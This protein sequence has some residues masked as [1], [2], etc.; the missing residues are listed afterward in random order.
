MRFCWIPA[1]WAL[2]LI[3]R[4]ALDRP[5]DYLPI[6]TAAMLK[7]A[8]FWADA[9][10]SGLPTAL[11]TVLDADIILA[12]QAAMLNDTEEPG[13]ALVVTDNVGHLDRFIAAR[14]WWDIP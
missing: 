6:T 10:R 5:I 14:R 7:A 8:E 1:S 12:A 9:R 13:G 2:S 3:P 11:E 4:T